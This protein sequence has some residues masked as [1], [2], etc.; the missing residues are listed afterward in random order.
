MAAESALNLQRLSVVHNVRYRFL[1]TWK[2]TSCCKG[3]LRRRAAC[4]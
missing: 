3:C 4:S 2:H 1:P